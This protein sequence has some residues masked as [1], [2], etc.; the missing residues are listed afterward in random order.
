MDQTIISAL[1]QMSITA[2]LSSTKTHED[3]DASAKLALTL[4]QPRKTI[5][6]HLTIIKQWCKHKESSATDLL[7]LISP[8]DISEMCSAIETLRGHTA[9][10]QWLK[11][12]DMFNCLRGAGDSIVKSQRELDYFKRTWQAFQAGSAS[13][14]VCLE[15]VDVY[16]GNFLFCGHTICVG[17]TNHLKD[18]RCPVCRVQV[19]DMKRTAVPLRPV[20]RKV[21]PPRR[22]TPNQV[23]EYT[24]RWSSKACSILET[25]QEIHRRDGGAKVLV[26]SQWNSLRCHLSQALRDGGVKHLSL[27]GNIFERSRVLQQFQS[28]A[29]ISLLLLSLEDSASGTNL[30]AASHVFLLHP[31]LAASDAEAASFEAQAVGR[32]RRLGQTKPVHVWRFMTLGTLEESLWEEC[33]LPR[34]ADAE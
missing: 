29:L 34:P 13:C 23:K 14:P 33:C 1:R 31:M 16:V 32:V 2:K 11:L 8:S 9:P 7:D 26:F 24:Q 28:D 6:A 21:V 22:L 19:P 18:S 4:S 20:D 30:T 3:Q 10:D 17:C 5:H 27:E 25:L 12:K 15:D